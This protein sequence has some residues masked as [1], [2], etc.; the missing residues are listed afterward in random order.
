MKKYYTTEVYCKTDIDIN[1]YNMQMELCNPAGPLSI[2]QYLAQ[3]GDNYVDQQI[4]YTYI[5][6]CPITQ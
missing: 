6:I 5:N 2:T 1:E 3:N 4:L